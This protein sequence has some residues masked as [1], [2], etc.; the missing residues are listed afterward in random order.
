VLESASPGIGNA[1]ERAARCAADEELAGFVLREGVEAFVDRWENVPVLAT[2]H[3]LPDAVRAEVRRV[4]STA[5]AQGL[6]QSLRLHGTGSMPFLG[7]R[8]GE[9]ACP[10]LLVTGA[11]DE[12][13]RAAAATMTKR[14][15]NARHAAVDGAGHTVHLE[16]ADEYTRHVEEFL[17][18]LGNEPARKQEVSTK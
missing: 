17:A 9:I 14:I 12:K 13:F 18:G 16:R 10:V 7:E 15:A 1:E 8:L 11:L 2:Q 6:A 3:G 5:S 4:R